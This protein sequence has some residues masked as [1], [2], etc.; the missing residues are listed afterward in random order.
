VKVPGARSGSG[1][2]AAGHGEARASR[3]TD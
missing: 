3:G 2:E 1:L